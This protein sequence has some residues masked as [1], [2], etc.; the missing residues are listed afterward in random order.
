MLKK[1][2]NLLCSLFPSTR[3][4]KKAGSKACTEET[5]STDTDTIDLHIEW[6]DLS[7]GMPESSTNSILCNAMRRQGIYGYVTPCLLVTEDGKTYMPEQLSDHWEAYIF[8]KK[9][10]P[11]SIKYK[12]L[13]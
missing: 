13:E 3:S 11:I 10:K 1:V 2:K 7:K 9:F 8:S 5:K 4:R 6:E 12:F